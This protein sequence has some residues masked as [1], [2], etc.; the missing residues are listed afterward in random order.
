MLL[1]FFGHIWSDS[2]LLGCAAAMLMLFTYELAGLAGRLPGIVTVRHLDLK[3]PIVSIGLFGTFYGVLTGLYGFDPKHISESVPHLL[4]GLKFA[5]GI[6]VIGMFLS[7]TLSI[8][9]TF[10]GGGEKSDDSILR[11]I[12]YKIGQLITP[13]D[14][15]KELVQQFVE[16]KSFLK[17]HLEDINSSLEKALLHLAQGATKEVTQ[18]LERI[19]TEFNENLKTQFGEN[20]KQ[21]NLAC[22]KLVEWQEK[23]R[24]HID[25]TESHLAEIIHSLDKARDA[26]RDLV[27]REEKTAAV[28]DKVG[29]LIRTY[30]LQ[31]GTLAT[32]LEQCKN[33]GNQAGSFLANTEK[34]LALSNENLDSF[35]RVIESSLGK[36]SEAL[37]QLTEDI[38]RQVPK[39]LGELEKVLTTITNQFAADYRSLFQ[40]IT[41]KR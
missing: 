29:G 5:F 37:A 36:Q 10:L 21:L 24:A 35:S 22:F 33:L 4:E 13:K 18:A 1:T 39:A 30:D 8:I 38:D 34:A 20:F 31:V 19:M 32:Y 14:S 2:F 27:A 12:D 40:F 6:S 28:C 25:A 15:S 17:G 7:L 16:M 3:T 23:Y 9:D 41:D 11:S 26:A